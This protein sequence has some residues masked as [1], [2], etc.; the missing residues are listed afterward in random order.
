VKRRNLFFNFVFSFLGSLLLLFIILPLIS[1][2]LGTTPQGFWLALTDP[3][4]L[5]SIGLTFA[6]AGAATSLALLT[7][8][9]L[10]YL[11]ARRQFRG[12]RLVEALVNLPIVIPHT[13]AGVALLLVFG[14][15]GLLGQWLTPLGVAFTDNFGGIVVGMLFVSL[16]FLVNMSRE[17]FAL[18]DD[19]LERVAMID[20]AT[21][22]GAF[23]HVTLPLAWRGV[24]G[25]AVMMWARGIS[26]FGA[27]VILAYHPK[28]VPVLVYERF[29]GFGLGAA[30]PVALLLII[31]AIAVFTFLRLTLL[32]EIKTNT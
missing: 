3:E 5:R 23:W 20:G 15:R 30:Q 25:G 4:V 31:V 10:A 2:L 27:V 26:E 14:R 19:E 9:P 6:A 28:I 12:K 11:L 17:S 1:T 21:A 32:P 29:N 8:V 24:L 7:G 18:V 13:A 22:W 16:P